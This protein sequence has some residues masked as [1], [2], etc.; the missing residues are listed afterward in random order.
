MIKLAKIW[1]SIWVK[2]Q[3]IWVKIVNKFSVGGPH[4][5]PY[6]LIPSMPS[7]VFM[8]YIWVTKTR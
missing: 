7:G 2:N 4:C 6:V 8:G 3:F 1:L 5:A